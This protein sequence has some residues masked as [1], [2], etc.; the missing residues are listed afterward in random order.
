MRATILVLVE[1]E[2]HTNV[3][4]LIRNLELIDNSIKI[5]EIIKN[6]HKVLP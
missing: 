3:I 1:N 6:E 5:L 4:N 2:V